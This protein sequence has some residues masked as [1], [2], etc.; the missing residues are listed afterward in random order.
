MIERCSR[1]MRAFERF[2]GLIAS[3][4]LLA[5]ML[6]IFCDVVLRYLLSS[7]LVWT[8]DAVSMYLM[9]AL[10]YLVVSDTLAE[11]HHI[12]VDLLKPRIPL[13]VQRLV[14]VLAGAAMAAIFVAIAW[15]FLHSAIDNLRKG[16][17]VMA[18]REWP[19]WIPEAIV[20]LGATT[21]ALRLVGR[22]IGH[23]GSLV[24]GR[25]LIDLPRS[26]EH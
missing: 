4:C 6:V 15:I 1:A 11:D 7:P 19:V 18:S 8:Y 5:V 21:I 9:P 16:A 12:A 10:F 13:P 25:S 23:A 3:V 24:T 2:L 17:V 14:E 26:T 20:F 22:V